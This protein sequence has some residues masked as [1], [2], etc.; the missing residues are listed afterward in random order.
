MVPSVCLYVLTHKWRKDPRQETPRDITNS[1]ICLQASPFQGENS[2][3][4]LVGIRTSAIIVFFITYLS[5]YL[6]SY[7]SNQV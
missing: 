2:D 7:L 5:I 1:T 4:F 6:A 3:M